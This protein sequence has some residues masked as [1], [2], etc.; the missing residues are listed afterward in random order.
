MG[1]LL[2]IWFF[3]EKV[4]PNKFTL[5]L[6]E[7][8]TNKQLKCP[9]SA[10]ILRVNLVRGEKL[11]KKDIGVLGMGKSDPYAILRVGAKRVE[12]PMIKNTIN[13]EWN[14]IADFPIEVVKGQIL[15]LELMDHDDPGKNQQQLPTLCR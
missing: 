4:L 3:S 7:S 8:V 5:S 11:M 9:D 13:P 15:H 2:K 6:A 10:G 1:R 12:T 14:F